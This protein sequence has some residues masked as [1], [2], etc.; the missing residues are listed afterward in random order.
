VLKLELHANVNFLRRRVLL[1]RTFYNIPVYIFT[2]C[3]AC[4][5]VQHLYLF[6]TAL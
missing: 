5:F 4:R 6:E 1:L 3:P 2:P